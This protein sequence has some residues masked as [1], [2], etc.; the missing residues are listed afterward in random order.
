MG[1]MARQFRLHRLCNFLM[2]RNLGVLRQYPPRVLKRDH[3]VPP[4]LVPEQAPSI[5]I[6]TPSFNQARFIE[7][8][9][10]SVLDQEYPNLEYIVQDGASTD[11]TVILLQTHQ[12]RL[13][14]W[15]STLD[16]GQSEALNKGFARTSGEIMGYLN[17]DDMLM[18]GSL[19]IV[20]DFFRSNPDV[21]VLYSH[22]LIINEEDQEI[23]RWFLPRHD[24]KA[25]LYA[26][27]IPQETMF[28]RRSIWEAAGSRVDP[29]FQFAMDWDLLLR[30]QANGAR[31]RRLPLF[32]AAFRVHP[33]SKT[34]R[35]LQ[36]VGSR[37]MIRLR[38]RSLGYL[39]SES[40]VMVRLTPYF[41]KAWA[42]RHLHERRC[43]RPMAPLLE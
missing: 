13:F 27:Y 28:W 34:E 17:S 41:I 14:H 23:G 6:V 29:T 35:L 7:R 19:G 33:G 18:P 26:D 42:L 32:L 37:E 16:H 22:R 40:E 1:L 30:F 9:V 12:K 43:L 39:P 21:D 24:P 15:E 36:T 20:A 8:T 2:R 25:L 4:R 5:S 38:R 10:L 11:N 31:I 3:L